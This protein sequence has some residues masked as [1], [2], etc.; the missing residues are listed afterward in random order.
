VKRSIPGKPWFRLNAQFMDV[1]KNRCFSG[2]PTHW[3]YCATDLNSAKKLF[4]WFALARTFV[5]IPYPMWADADDLW[6]PD[7]PAHLEPRILACA[8]AIVFAENECVE[9]YFPANN[10]LPGSR[11]IYAGNPLS[12]LDATS[13][14]SQTI[15]PQVNAATSPAGDDL[16]AGVNQL[17]ALWDSRFVHC[18]EIPIGYKP[19]YFVDERGLTRHAGL[20]QIRDFARNQ[21]DE[22]LLTALAVVQTM[23]KVAKAEFH[24][25]VTAPSGLNYLG[26]VPKIS[27][28]EVPSS[29]NFQKVLARR[30]A[31]AGL[32]VNELHGDPNFGRTKLAKLFYLADRMAGLQLQADYAREAAGPLDQRAL[33]NERFGIEAL[34]V[35]HQVFKSEKRGRM[36]RYQRI[37]DAATIDLFAREQL[38]KKADQ[39][40]AIIDACRSLST[41]QTEIIAT[42]HA[43]WN[44]LLLKQRS[45][46]DDA[47]ITEFYGHWHPLKTRFSHA[48]LAKAIEWMR[49]RDFVPTGSGS[50]TRNR[51]PS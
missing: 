20:V 12:P 4:F 31:L 27:C 40:I 29:T 46:T 30:V 7:I 33:Y 34:A 48:R 21:R 2:P 45:V 41:D 26:R 50:P 44:D 19:P 17:Y 6:A 25:V 39:V 36:V 18:R 3:G 11:E 8:A 49:A 5:Q 9:T 16:I 51:P 23:L 14:W 35:R 13:F 37:A 43:C 15:V 42:L 24:D 28:I 38:G 1:K 22:Q 47:I 32:L 10:P